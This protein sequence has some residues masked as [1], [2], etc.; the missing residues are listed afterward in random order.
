MLDNTEWAFAQLE[1]T[2]CHNFLTGPAGSGKST[3]IR[4]F[5]EK[6]HDETLVC[7][8]TG[9]AAVN[10]GGVTIHK[11]FSFP[12]IPVGYSGIKHLQPDQRPAD[13]EKWRIFKAAKYIIIDEISMVR[14]DVMDQI[15]W[16][17]HKNFN[18]DGPM[19][20]KKI[21]MVGDIDQLPPV[22]ASDKDKEM[23]FKRNYASPYFMD[24][25]CW[26]P[27]RL[28][29]F[30]TIAL[31]KVWRQ[32]DPEFV[33]LLNSIK[34]NEVSPLDIDRL[35]ARCYKPKEDNGGV[36]LCAT[37]KIAEE[38]NAH[39]LAQVD[40]D[41]IYSTGE[42]SG[43]FPDSAMACAKLMELRPGCRIMTIVNQPSKGK[44]AYVNGS[45]GTFIERV[46]DETGDRLV[47]QFDGSEEH[48]EVGKFI[49]ENVDYVYDPE[50][51]KVKSEVVGRYTQFP[52]KLA[53]ALTIHKS[54][55]QSFDKI[56]ID[57]G[58]RGAFAHGQTYVAL[59]RCR[60][61]DGIILKRPL[62]MS[63]FVYDKV[64]EQFN[65]KM[66]QLSDS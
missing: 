58:H 6:H 39:R 31:T 11:L 32:A 36:L 20:G 13:A 2:T 5:I 50:K 26:N 18:A 56:M 42:V 63:D 22:V 35:N 49:F 29:S 48:I 3:L 62:S 1:D 24:A 40:A 25:A 60:S 8:S 45:I 47:I 15:S 59:S 19:G 23:L 14:V 41:P 43:D 28:T 21:I 65:K 27:A 17:L 61:I 12:I 10:I 37:N 54:Q 64:V 7:A 38:T 57:L 33:G 9:I 46:I 34:R 55:G 16:F 53:Y 30:K 66:L 4:K 52:I 51:D 44:P